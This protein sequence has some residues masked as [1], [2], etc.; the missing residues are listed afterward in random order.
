MTKMPS[1]KH[2][3]CT[4]AGPIDYVVLFVT[5]CILKAVAKI[6]RYP[7]F[8]PSENR[9]A[10]NCILVCLKVA[11][12]KGYLTV[13]ACKKGKSIWERTMEGRFCVL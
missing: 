4:L 9:E 5:A 3:A 8:I 12:K 7:V 11:L 2:C 10:F 1:Y 6:T 13:Q